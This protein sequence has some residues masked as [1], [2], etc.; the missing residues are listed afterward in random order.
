MY[1]K[2]EIRKMVTS[3]KKEKLEAPTVKRG[4]K[5]KNHQF[6]L[7]KTQLVWNLKAPTIISSDGQ[8]RYKIKRFW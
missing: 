1:R 4:K 5:N 2:K 7:R 8:K 3:S 6:Y